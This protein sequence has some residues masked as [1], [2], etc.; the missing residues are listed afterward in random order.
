MVSSRRGGSS[1]ILRRVSEP[2]LARSSPYEVLRNRDFLL[3]LIGR[4]IASFG[5]QMVTVA[6]GWQLYERTHKPLAL[7]LV[8]LTQMIP[9]IGL[10]LPAGHFADNHDRK[11]I[12]IT[13]MLLMSVASV[14]LALSSFFEAAVG[15]IYACLFMTGCA[16]TFLWPA[17]SAFMPQLVSKALFPRAVTWNSGSFHLSSVL[18]PAVGGL[19]IRFTHSATPVYVFEAVA[20]L[21]CALMVFLLHATHTPLKKE[22]MTL[23]SLIVGFEFVFATEIILATITLDLFAVLLGGAVSLLP[24]YAKDILHAG[25]DGLGLLQA[26]LP[27][28]SVLCSAYV[29]HRPPFEKAGRTLLWAVA[30]FGLAT[31]IF[32]LSKNFWLSVAMLVVCGMTDNVSVVVRHT[33]VQILTPDDKRGRVSAVN[34]LFIGTSNEL[35]GFESGFVAQYLGPVV[36]VVAG[37][38]GTILVAVLVG[39][40]WPQLKRYGRLGST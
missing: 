7:G 3:Y 37:G 14:G 26:A 5:Q 11:R 33:L 6:V 13:G 20:L 4:F 18:G 27:I 36:S 8:G 30:G 40:K 2:G 39:M 17:S 32:G 12:I 35:G 34:S 23:R 29:A 9:M 16:R 22:P 15:W 31:I 38:V 19:V 25:P 28:G 21:T 1:C 10:T 24:V